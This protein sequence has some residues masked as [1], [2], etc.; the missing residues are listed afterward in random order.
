MAESLFFL[1]IRLMMGDEVIFVEEEGCRFKSLPNVTVHYNLSLT[2]YTYGSVVYRSLYLKA[3]NVPHMSKELKSW[4]HEI[5][6]LSFE[7]LS[8]FFTT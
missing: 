1:S 4:M 7:L 3:G 6:L 2:L 5:S 8:S